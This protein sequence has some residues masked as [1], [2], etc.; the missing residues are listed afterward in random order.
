MEFWDA[1]RR[2]SGVL[3]LVGSALDSH[4]LLQ[5][6]AFLVSASIESVHVLVAAKSDK[7]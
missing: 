1:A 6:L 3:R 2:I 5:A 7:I 4:G